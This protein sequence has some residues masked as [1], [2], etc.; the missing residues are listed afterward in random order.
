M[1]WLYQC[2]CGY[3]LGMQVKATEVTCKCGSKIKPVEIDQDMYRKLFTS[4]TVRRA[5]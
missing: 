4:K 5:K 2:K 3:K 1:P